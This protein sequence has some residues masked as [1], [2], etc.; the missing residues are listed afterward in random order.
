MEQVK[1]RQIIE[2]AHMAGQKSRSPYMSHN[3]AEFNAKIYRAT[4]MGE[5]GREACENDKTKKET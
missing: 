4:V 3:R 1:L 5:L 2:D